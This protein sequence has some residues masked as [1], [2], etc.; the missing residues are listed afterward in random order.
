[1]MTATRHY[2]N[3]NQHAVVSIQLDIVTSYVSREIRLR[4]C[5]CTVFTTCHCHSLCQFKLLEFHLWTVHILHLKMAKGGTSP[6][7]HR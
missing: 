6:E 2:P 3:P 1:M 5:Y 7:R 4:H